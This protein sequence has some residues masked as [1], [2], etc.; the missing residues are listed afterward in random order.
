MKLSVNATGLYND[1]PVNCDRGN[2]VK[3]MFEK[4]G[5]LSILFKHSVRLPNAALSV[6]G[7]SI[8]G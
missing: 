7:A 8:T 2:T 3:R 6:I 4:Y 1:P 5:K